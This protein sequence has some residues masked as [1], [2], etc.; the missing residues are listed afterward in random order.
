MGQRNAEVTPY[1]LAPTR[2]WRAA[3]TRE[4]LRQSTPRA[5]HTL[6]IE[7]NTSHRGPCLGCRSRHCQHGL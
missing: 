4:S 2:R 7:Q 1:A 6:A 3:Q 5:L